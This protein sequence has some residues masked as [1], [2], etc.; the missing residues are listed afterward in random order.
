MT[1]PSM[2]R[3]RAA[4][5]ARRAGGDMVMEL[6]RAIAARIRGRMSRAGSGAASQREVRQ[7][8]RSQIDMKPALGFRRSDAVAEAQTA[9]ARCRGL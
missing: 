5:E 3:V 7:S 8:L 9:L 4:F 2:R 6:K 1:L